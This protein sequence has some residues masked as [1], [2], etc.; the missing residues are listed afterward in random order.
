MGLHS[1]NSPAKFTHMSAFHRAPCLEFTVC[2]MLC[3]SIS[4]TSTRMPSLVR[5]PTIILGTPSRNDWIQNF[6]SLRWKLSMSWSERISAVVLSSTQFIGWPGWGLESHTGFLVRVVFFWEGTCVQGG[7][8]MLASTSP[9]R[10]RTVFP[11][12]VRTTEQY[13]SL[14]LTI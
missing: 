6:M 14:L 9:P 4:L 11:M 10:Q 5:K 12:P 2:G 3:V 1:R 13:C 7:E 8:N